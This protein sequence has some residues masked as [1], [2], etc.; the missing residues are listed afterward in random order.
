MR[1]KGDISG[2]VWGTAVGDSL[3]LPAEGISPAEIKKLGWH[4][5][6]KHRFICGRG[7]LSDDTE[8]TLMVLEALT[9]AI[10]GA[11]A[12]AQLGRS[13]IPDEWVEPINDWP[14]GKSFIKAHIQC[15]HD[16]RAARSPFFLL[17]LA[18]NLIFLIIVLLHGLTRLIPFRMR[19]MLFTD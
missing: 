4:D 6:W 2:L 11:L 14:K 13:G 12:G 9:A 8:H 5:N 15:I 10:L 19:K 7:M 1:N 16:G 17:Q 18:R 3:G